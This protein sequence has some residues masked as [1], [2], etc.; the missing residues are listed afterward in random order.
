[1]RNGAILFNVFSNLLVYIMSIIKLHSEGNT[2]LIDKA[3]TLIKETSWLTPV[4]SMLTKAASN[5]GRDIQNS[6]NELDN[7]KSP[8]LL[9]LH[10]RDKAVVMSVEH[11]SQL[12]EMS[13]VLESMLEKERI[14]ALSQA[15]ND[16]ERM[17]QSMTG[18]KSG[19]AAMH[20]LNVSEEDLAATFQPGGPEIR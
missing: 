19:D 10:R 8:T 4:A 17:Y 16:F 20:L 18:E 14:D 7:D 1:M 11:Y 13:K 15:G 5:F 3:K 12:L 9:K 6:L 2:N